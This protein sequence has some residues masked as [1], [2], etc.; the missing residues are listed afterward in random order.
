MAYLHSFGLFDD[1]PNEEWEQLCTTMR[2]GSWYAK[3]DNPLADVYAASPWIKKN[4][5]PTFVCPRM[6]LVGLGG[7][8]TKLMCYPEMLSHRTTDN[9]F[10]ITRA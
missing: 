1:I 8:Q 2:L 3:L 6:G 9:D 5:N 7:Q 4:T 10:N